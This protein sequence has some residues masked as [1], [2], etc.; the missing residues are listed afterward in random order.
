MIDVMLLSSLAVV[1]L[2][3][4]CGEELNEGQRLSTGHICCGN[5]SE[6]SIMYRCVG[7]ESG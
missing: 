1:K 4:E 2:W 6:S 7:S 5:I 3:I